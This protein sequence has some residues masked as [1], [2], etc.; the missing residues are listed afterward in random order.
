MPLLTNPTLDQLRRLK[1]ANLEELF[2][3]RSG[4][5]AVE[6]VGIGPRTTNSPTTVSV[7]LETTGENTVVVLINSILFI[8]PL[9]VLVATDADGTEISVEPSYV[10][11]GLF[12][13]NVSGAPT[14]PMS[15]PTEPESLDLPVARPVDPTSPTARLLVKDARER[16]QLMSGAHIGV[17]FD[18]TGFDLDQDGNAIP[19]NDPGH[20][21]GTLGCIAQMLDTNKLV[22]LT[23][24]HVVVSGDHI[25]ATETDSSGEETGGQVITGKFRVIERDGDAVLQVEREGTTGYVDAPTRRSWREDNGQRS[26]EFIVG[27]PTPGNCCGL[28][29]DNFGRVHVSA[30]TRQVDA[31]AV[32]LEESSTEQCFLPMILGGTDLTD[33]RAEMIGPG[34]SDA[35]GTALPINGAIPADLTL[36]DLQT[37]TQNPDG[38]V[39][40]RLSYVVHKYGFKTGF[41]SGLVR[42]IEYT[43]NTVNARVVK[44]PALLSGEEYPDDDPRETIDVTFPVPDDFIY[45]IPFEPATSELGEL[46]A[47]SGDSGSA[48]INTNGQVVGLVTSGVAWDQR[49]LDPNFPGINFDNILGGWGGSLQKISNVTQALGV[50]IPAFDANLRIRTVPDGNAD[51]ASASRAPRAVPALVGALPA[52]FVA[53]ARRLF[54]EVRRL[55]NRNR[56]VTVAW[57]RSGGPS[58]AWGLVRALDDAGHRIPAEVHG[59][60]SVELLRGFLDVLRAECRPD[61][62]DTIEELEPWLL[63]MPGSTILEVAAKLENVHWRP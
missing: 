30:Y 54:P 25:F 13:P 52:P 12:K 41:T 37:R 32:L 58:L 45:V 46:F 14:Q 55:V 3:R 5:P 60:P 24:H 29:R 11:H 27:H 23:C 48:A 63:Q 59:K 61:S 31:A 4:F 44:V 2:R 35:I 56:R 9:D 22:A 50:R 38:S 42:C 53:R 18:K 16:D 20:T 33:W 15:G 34:G 49:P 8:P 40:W 10:A 57:H 17:Y 21:P 1:S 19:K 43:H 62:I 7:D 26:D 28:E 47:A 51:F 36:S 39:T 6:G